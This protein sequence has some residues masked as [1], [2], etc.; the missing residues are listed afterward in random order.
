[1]YPEMRNQSNRYEESSAL[2]RIAW[3]CIGL[4]V[5]PITGCAAGREYGDTG[6]TVRTGAERLFTDRYHLV[7]SRRVGL[8]TNHSAIVGG[9]HLADR[10]HADPS[11]ELVALFGPEHGIRGTADAG[12]P[13]D[14]GVDERTGVPVYS[15]YGEIDRPTAE[16]LEGVDVLIFDIQDVGARFYTYPATMGRAMKSAAEAGIP[17]LVLD[18]PNPIAGLPVEGPV[19]EDRFR[20]GIGLYPTPITHGMTVGELALMIKGERWH[21]GI[22]DLDLHVVEMEGWTRGMLWP[23]TGMEWVA[24]S[25]NIPD[26]ETAIVYPGTCFF[27]GT[28][29]SE[30]RGTYRPFLQVG[31]P[32]VNSNAVADELNRRDLPGL[33]FS[34]V[35]FV[36]E[37]IEGM[38][39][40]PK[41]LGEEVHGVRIEITEPAKVR[42]VEAGIHILQAVYESLPT[43]ARE[44][45]FIERGLNIRAGNEE[46]L[47]KL[48]EGDRVDRIVAGWERDVERFKIEREPYLIYD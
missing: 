9:Q 34:P 7:E 41:L 21:E 18:R 33:A 5:V 20:S 22:E 40:Q 27:E 1:M 4:S 38:S 12:E 32:Y 19:R 46:V 25:P 17:Y 43:E 16:M 36:P 6:T 29:A 39:K 28:T 10:L 8:V 14:H 48:R 44:T 2:S 23:D 47:N 45:F 13:V 3:L 42:P 37:S 30:G 24:P 26:V 31:S 11:I 35:T 15:L